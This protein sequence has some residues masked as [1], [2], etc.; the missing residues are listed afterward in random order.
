MSLPFVSAALA[1]MLISSPL[2]ASPVKLGEQF[3]HK[4]WSAT[5]DNSLA[6][7]ALSLLPEGESSDSPQIIISRGSG[8]AAVSVRIRFAEPTGGRYR[9]LVGGRVVANGTQAA[10]DWPIMVDGDAALKLVRAIARGRNLTIDD[11]NGRLLGKR[12][13]AGSVAALNRI[14][15]LQN[16]DGTRLAL[17]SVGRRVKSAAVIIPPVVQAKRIGKQGPLPDAATIVAVVEGSKCEI[18]PSVVTENSAVSLGRADGQ[19]KALLFV[20]CGSGAYNSATAAY[21]GTSVDGKRW[22]FAPARFDY[23]E[24]PDEGMGGVTLLSNVSWDASR[25]RLDA[26][27]KGRGLGDCGQAESYVWDGSVFRLVEARAMN[28]CRG[29]AEWPIVW[30]A[31]IEFRD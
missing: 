9:V 6:C 11:G 19:R 7:E 24:K 12:D 8:D 23:P 15:A 30:R 14:D 28:E 18:D 16:R 2:A 5:C 1:A 10:G 4:N 26:F 29:I 21:F 27:H 17:A 25:Q 3:F 31:R 22:D 20:S 13:L